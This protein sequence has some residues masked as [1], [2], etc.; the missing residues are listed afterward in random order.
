MFGSSLTF[1][2]RVNEDALFFMTDRDAENFTQEDSREELI[3]EGRTDL[4][5]SEIL[6]RYYV[7]VIWIQS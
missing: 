2:H 7:S 1:T 6:A 3:K 5:P 4:I